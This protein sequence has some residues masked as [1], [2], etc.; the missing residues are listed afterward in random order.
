MMLN[1][2]PT[3]MEDIKDLGVIDIGFNIE[4]CLDLAMKYPDIRPMMTFSNQDNK[5]VFICGMSHISPGVWEAWLIPG[6]LLKTHAKEAVKTLKEFTDWVLDNNHA[7]RV[8]I[9]VLE[10]NKKWAQALGFQFEA[11][12]KN[13]HSNKDHYMFI[14]VR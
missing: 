4:E 13:Y 9:A 1:A 6:N 12:V 5:A 7:H 8:Q 11:I 3:K 10:N 14:K 2:T